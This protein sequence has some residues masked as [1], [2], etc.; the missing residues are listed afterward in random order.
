MP[1]VLLLVSRKVHQ[2][3]QPQRIYNGQKPSVIFVFFAEQ[4]FAL[5]V[6]SDICLDSSNNKIRW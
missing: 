3:Y 6:M 1:Q 4:M 2:I 5:L